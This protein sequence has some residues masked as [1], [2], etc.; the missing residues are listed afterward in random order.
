MAPVPLTD[1]MMCGRLP[2][3]LSCDTC[4]IMMCVRMKVISCFVMTRLAAFIALMFICVIVA[5][6]ECHKKCGIL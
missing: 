2:Y 6:A 5:S 3:L 4:V 1:F